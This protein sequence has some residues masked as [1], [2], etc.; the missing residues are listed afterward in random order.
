MAVLLLAP[1]ALVLVLA[2]CNN[3][4][5]SATAPGAAPPTSTPPSTSAAPSASLGPVPSVVVPPSSPGRPMT[6]GEK[7]YRQLCQAGTVRN[8]CDMYSDNALRLQGINPDS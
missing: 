1:T 7:Q 5:E 4:S 6:Q 2:G 8:G 3:S